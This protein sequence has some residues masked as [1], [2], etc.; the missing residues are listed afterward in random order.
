VNAPT[1]VYMPHCDMELY[2]NLLSAN[3]KPQIDALKLLF[4]ANQLSDYIVK[5]VLLVS[6]QVSGGLSCDSN[7]LQVLKDKAP[8][9]VNIGE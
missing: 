6:L 9:L 1:I 5:W 8:Y 7:P 3:W 4:I 2:E